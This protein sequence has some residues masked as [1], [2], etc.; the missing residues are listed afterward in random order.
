MLTKINAQTEEELGK[1]RKALAC[2][3]LMKLR[4]KA[5]YVRIFLE[6]I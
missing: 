3:K 5:D 2:S 4:I 1:K 6:K